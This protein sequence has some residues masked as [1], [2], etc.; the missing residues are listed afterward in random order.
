MP[1]F[2]VNGISIPEK[3]N[4]TGISV[5]STHAVKIWDYLTKNGSIRLHNDKKFLE[6]PGYQCY[7]NFGN[8]GHS[9]E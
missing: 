2:E 6:H 3:L 1:F 5:V 4:K 9:L 7:R 8:N